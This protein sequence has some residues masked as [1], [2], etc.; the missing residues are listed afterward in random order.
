MADVP[1]VQEPE[2]Q[3]EVKQPVISTGNPEIDRK[4]GGGIPMGSLT[5]VE[6]QSDAGKSVL[7]QQ[8][9]WGSV[10]AR[11]KAV[12]YTNENTVRSLVKQ[13]ESLSLEIF[14]Q[15]LLGWLRIYPVQVAQGF[16][17]SEVFR[18]I[19]RSMQEQASH[20]LVVVDSLTQFITY[21]STEDVLTF[22]EECKGLCDDGKT[23]III[24]HTYAFKE[25]I[26]IRLS[27]MCDAH[28]RLR[29]E[30]LG[31]QLVK[32]L[33]VAKIRGAGRS[34]GNVISFEVEP[35]LGMRLI[36]VSKVKV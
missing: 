16:S 15:L 30:E 17:A 13:M 7:T 2:V 21:T 28:L 29:I 25:E 31:D 19:V 34:T 11:C 23:I 1:E 12:V 4:M 6:G 3:E 14:D 10:K 5:L 26:L 18:I 35:G 24:A 8:L 32:V 36:P 27:S 20:N 33:E 22:F 9:L